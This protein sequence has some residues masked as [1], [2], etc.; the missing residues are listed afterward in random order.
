MSFSF[1]HQARTK[2]AL[3]EMAAVSFAGVV[4]QQPAHSRDVPAI[5]KAAEG[6]VA[7]AADPAEHQFLELDVSASLWVDTATGSVRQAN[8]QVNVHVC[9]DPA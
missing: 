6:H 5:E 3:L 9:N 2:A 4:E 7:I 8:F 1:K